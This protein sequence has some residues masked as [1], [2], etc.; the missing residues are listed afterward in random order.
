MSQLES[1]E[2]P[3]ADSPEFSGSDTSSIGGIWPP[4]DSS[5]QR[6]KAFYNL[7]PIH[8][9]RSMCVLQQRFEREV[10]R[11]NGESLTRVQF[12]A[13]FKE[14]VLRDHSND[15]FLQRHIEALIPLEREFQGE[16]LILAYLGHNDPTARPCSEF[17]LQ[18]I[19][20]NYDHARVV[21]N[22]TA[23]EIFSRALSNGYS[24]EI[25]PRDREEDRDSTITQLANLYGRFNRTKDN[26]T[27]MLDNPLNTFA[28]VRNRNQI[29]SAAIAESA[30]ISFP[31]SDL[32]V[33]EIT[34]AAT[35]EGF[36]NLGLY[37]A[38]STKLL[39]K[40]ASMSYYK[41]MGY[42]I[43]LVF[44]ECNALSRG[45]L[46]AVKRQ[47]RTFSSEIC[48]E[49]GFPGQRL[50]RQQVPISGVEK[51]TRYN[52]LL[53]AYLVPSKLYEYYLTK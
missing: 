25:L 8:N 12:R 28:V 45:V 2:Q 52:D 39:V 48:G 20:E 4:K 13:L 36:G 18:V 50:L 5:D 43:D 27:E 35:L 32:H 30:E 26:V 11:L 23:S 22:R 24:I 31:G 33:V 49:F 38:V 29:I 37:T 16:R 46:T 6:I 17:D 42:E 7:R 41:T 44:G 9:D 34:E 47:G 3:F 19:R 40:L 15:P 1:Q 10:Q 21:E 14:P 53:P 51:K